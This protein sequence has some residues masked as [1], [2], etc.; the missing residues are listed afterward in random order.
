MG[1]SLSWTI[2]VTNNSAT[3]STVKVVLKA[4]TSGASYNN[5]SP[6]GYITIGGTKYTF[7]HNIP[8]SS[9]T[10]LATKS[11]TFSRIAGNQSIAVKASFSTGIS[12]GT[13]TKSGTATVPS[14]D[15]YGVYWYWDSSWASVYTSTTVYYGYAATHPS[16]S[17]TGYNF[18]GWN[19]A[20][21]AGTSTGGI[22]ATTY[23]YATWSPITYS[24]AYD[25]N[26][27]SEAP[28]ST[29]TT[30]Y[31]IEQTVAIPDP[32]REG[33][34]FTGWT[35]SNG[36]T[37]Q[38]VQIPVGSTGNRTYTAN[39]EINKY[40]LILNTNEHEYPDN[41]SWPADSDPSNNTLIKTHGINI[42]LPDWGEGH[43]N[44]NGTYQL[45]AGWSVTIGSTEVAIGT[46]FDRDGE[47]MDGIFELKANWSDAVRSIILHY[48][49]SATTDNQVTIF[50]PFNQA[51]ALP[52]KTT[53]NYAF[54][55][56]HTSSGLPSTST[57]DYPVSGTMNFTE[58]GVWFKPTEDTE[59]PAI[60]SERKTYYQESGGT[61]SE[62]DKES[63]DPTINPL[64]EGYYEMV[65]NPP[66]KHL[67]AVWNPTYTVR[68][69]RNDPSV[70]DGLS[71]SG[72]VALMT[73]E[74]G[75]QFTLPSA[76]Y[77]R[78]GYTVSGW[79]TSSTATTITSGYAAGATQTISNQAAGYELNLYAVWTK[80]KY[81][82]T[83][84]RG[85]ATSGNNIVN[86]YDYYS[87]YVLP[88]DIPT[89][90][91]YANWKLNK[92]TY[93][94]GSSVV[95]P[96]STMRVVRD[97]TFVAGW[98]YKYNV[99]NSIVIDTK[100]YL[101]SDYTILN[102]G[103]KYLE[104]HAVGING[105][106]IGASVNTHIY[107]VEVKFYNVTNDNY[108]RTSDE[109]PDNNKIYYEYGSS[110]YVPVINPTGNVRDKGYFEL[111]VIT[112]TTRPVATYE[113][114]SIP[115]TGTNF[116]QTWGKKD[117]PLIDKGL[118]MAYCFL[119]IKDV[120]DYNSDFSMD[121]PDRTITYSFPVTLKRAIAIH[122]ANDTKAIS[123]FGELQEG[124]NGLVVRGPVRMIDNEHNITMDLHNLI[125]IIRW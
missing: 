84:N 104:I 111:V 93:N 112:E 39:W 66:A 113:L 97:Q 59:I 67:Y 55:G 10:T 81:T 20:Y 62:I 96:G 18:T 24:I 85:E 31:N 49:D 101:D 40:Q 71:A 77:S 45:F 86:Q 125:Q 73:V 118:N 37:P 75:A 48:S 51:I 47:V 42:A 22:G 57:P 28:N 61:Y 50:Q 34:T 2:S 23:Y 120:T 13:L 78:A 100:R 79:A 109:E 114:L 30:S 15:V 121:S 65:Q 21:A 82:I 16:I 25:L 7:S 5:T 110:G 95:N 68:F 53:N 123:M 124:D 102:D 56:W 115:S 36:T 88:S 76:N 92:W 80:R 108:I 64:E 117:R 94:D 35:G 63:L 3:Q 1:V 17:K 107:N 4:T 72:S 87:T 12:A 70:G 89:G 11:K 43:V 46:T 90:W 26:G 69:N 98:T 116:E 32:I 52:R 9:T 29:Y 105:S 38:N 8:K 119:T 122:I 54:K 14:L 99:A 74:N 58:Y 91:T 33:Y 103:G 106:Y 27:G 19:G 83:L 60:P 6:S 41:W 44:R